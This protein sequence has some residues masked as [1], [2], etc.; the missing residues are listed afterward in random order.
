[1]ESINYYGFKITYPGIVRSLKSIVRIG[2]PVFQNESPVVFKRNISAV[3]D[4][5]STNSCI[6]ENIAFDFCLEKSRQVIC[7]A[8]HSQSMV[9]TY[10]ASLILPN[11]LIINEIELCSSKNLS[12]GDLLIGMDVISKGEFLVSTC[13]DIT[14]YSFQSPAETLLGLDQ[15]S[16]RQ[17]IDVKFDEN[18]NKNMLCPCGS[19]LLFEYYC[20]NR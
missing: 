7:N 2:F 11:G 13:N 16:F 15:I 18:F 8:V 6:S 10:L 5:G 1:M 3:W 14:T 19:M 17:A 12:T 9:N 20:A 4:T